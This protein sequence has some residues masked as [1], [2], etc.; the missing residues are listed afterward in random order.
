[1]VNIMRS[2]VV[3]SNALDPVAS[4]V[5]G[6]LRT[7]V[8]PQGPAT[9]SFEK[10]ADSLLQVQPELLVLV[11]PPSADAGLEMVRTLRRGLP[12]H[13]IVVGQASDPKLILR[14]LQF[15]A[16]HYVDQADLET[17]LE[18]GVSRLKLKQEAG[19][20]TGRLLAVLGASGGVG[21]STLAVN[22]AATLAKQGGG[23]VLLDLNPGRGDLAALLDLK[24]QFNL[25]DLCL[26]VARLDRAIFE[27]MLV[28]HASGVRL[29]GAPQMFG[30]LRAV[31]AQGV[32]QA[33][34]MA[35]KIFPFTVVDLEDCFHEE[36]VVTLRQASS[37]LLVARLDFTSL[38]NAR[39]ILE[40]LTQ[41]EVHHAQVRVVIN[42][43][44]Q[45]NEL[46]VAEAEDA[47]GHKLVHFVPDDS[48][49]VN[50]AN[51]AGIPVVLNEPGARVSQSVRQL[52]KSVF[53]RRGEP[54]VPASDL[55]P[56]AWK[57][58]APCRL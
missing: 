12:G 34:A 18:A 15:G 57:G 42:R 49:T 4:K 14:A 30:D 44:G 47:L 43:S 48:K 32:S 29:L 21:A 25:A 33:L 17:E 46:P 1:M 51:N 54:A 11:L 13:L 26:N 24:P 52:A 16:D 58:V 2:L 31:T 9:T 37:V 10:A 36:Q 20:P 56:A 39:R 45:P 5:R 27:K 53:E 23:S 6:L 50:R 3:S 28:E 40:H 8:D 22:L 19:A 55:E 35:R 38:R 7:L 41:L